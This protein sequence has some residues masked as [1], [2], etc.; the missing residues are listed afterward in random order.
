MGSFGSPPMGS[1]SLPID[2]Y[3][4]ALTVLEVPSVRSS[5]PDLMANSDLEAMTTCERSTKAKTSST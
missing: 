4:V 2:T 5:D 3:G 1:C